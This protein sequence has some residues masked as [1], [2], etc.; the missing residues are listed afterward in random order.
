MKGAEKWISKVLVYMFP[1]FNEKEYKTYNKKV[2]KI[3][4]PSA[5]F[6]QIFKPKPQKSSSSSI[7]KYLS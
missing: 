4:D 2:N 5:W 1:G 7:Q 6:K 3:T